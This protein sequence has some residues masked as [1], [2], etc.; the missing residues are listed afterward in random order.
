M[1]DKNEAGT[2]KREQRDREEREAELARSTEDEHEI[3]Q[4]ERRAE[5][6]HYLRKKL[7]EREASEHQ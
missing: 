6:A 3:A 2:L 4:H 1:D 7:E 5:R